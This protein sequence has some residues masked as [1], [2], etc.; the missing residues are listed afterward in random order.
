MRRFLVSMFILLPF[1]VNANDALLKQR[2]VQQFIQSMVTHHGFSKQEVIAT[3]SQVDIQPKI[4]ESISHPYEKKTWDIY[5]ALFLNDKRLNN[6]LIFW[7]K[8]Q[9]TL[10]KVENEYGVPA[11][12]IVAT[13]G[14]ETLYGERQGDYRVLDALSTLA[15]E[16]PPRSPFFTKEL[17]HFLILCKEHHVQ[18]TRYLGS[19][20][21]AMGK[22]QFMPSSYRT[23]AVDYAHK[24][25]SDLM[26]DDNDAIASVANYYARH[27]WAR[28]NAIT[29]P[30][31]ISGRGYRSVN[32]QAR[33][34]TYQMNRLNTLGIRPAGTLQNRPQK[35]G[36][37]E[38]INQKN[39]EYWIAYPNFYV[40]TRYNTSPQYAMAVFL[41]AEQL[42]KHY[43]AKS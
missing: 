26:N 25:R 42:K 10:R 37:L 24:G 22:T 36:L 15:F 30:A 28:H 18:P 34:A 12:I 8:N 4:I 33:S 41:L 17:E 43:G 13:I 19:Y 31:N 14:V 40:I 29:E 16:Y 38:L 5:K 21:G 11:E 7:R 1:C 35:A 27:G 3:L 9:N 2:N 32:V 39:S 23:F 6:G 20:A